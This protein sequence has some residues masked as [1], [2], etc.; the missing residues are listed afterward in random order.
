MSP[1]TPHTEQCLNLDYRILPRASELGKVLNYFK[2]ILNYFKESRFKIRN[3][4]LCPVYIVD[5]FIALLMLLNTKVQNSEV[6][7]RF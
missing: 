6:N 1:G 3:F 2:E 4:V 7:S 5:V